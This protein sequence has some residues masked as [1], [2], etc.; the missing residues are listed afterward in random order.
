MGGE[1]RPEYYFICQR[2]KYKI[3]YCKCV[4]GIFFPDRRAILRKFEV[5]N[6]GVLDSVLCAQ[7]V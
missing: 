1:E 3:L 2:L 4:H 7:T 5:Q 6:Q